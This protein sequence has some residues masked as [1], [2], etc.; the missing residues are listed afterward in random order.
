MY[1]DCIFLTE[2]KI[3]I[4]QYFEKYFIVTAQ[5]GQVSTNLGSPWAKNGHFYWLF[6]KKITWEPHIVHY[7]KY[8]TINFIL[9]FYIYQFPKL[10]STDLN[11]TLMISLGLFKFP[12]NQ[13]FHSLRTLLYS[14]QKHF[15]GQTRQICFSQ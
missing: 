10:S 8:D 6:S 9:Y 15:S 2:M 14:Y 13:F 3:Q 1:W 5:F 4:Q 11:W 12:G 7:M